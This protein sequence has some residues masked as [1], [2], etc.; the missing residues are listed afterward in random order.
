VSLNVYWILSIAV[1]SPHGS[2]AW[3]FLRHT[4]T[5]A[6]DK[7][8]STYGAIGCRRST[9][10]D[11]ELNAAS[12]WAAAIVAALMNVLREIAVL[13]LCKIIE[14]GPRGIPGNRNPS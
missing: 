11:T 4:Q 14:R 9:W 13:P 10:N 8:T 3:Q 6:M 12:G 5:P 7:L 1:G 2:V